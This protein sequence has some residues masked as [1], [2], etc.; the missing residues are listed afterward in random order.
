MVQG[1]P[2]KGFQKIPYMLILITRHM[3]YSWEKN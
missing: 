2:Y 3:N 1:Q